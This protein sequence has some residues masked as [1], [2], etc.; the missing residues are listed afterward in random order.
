MPDYVIL[1]SRDV[2]IDQPSQ[3]LHAERYALDA[4]A[5]LFFDGQRREPVVAYA[6]GA[7]VYVKVVT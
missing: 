2:R 1:L 7:W 6:S 3:A 4:G 5:L